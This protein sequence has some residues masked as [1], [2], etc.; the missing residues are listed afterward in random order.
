MGRVSNRMGCHAPTACWEGDCRRKLSGARGWESCAAAVRGGTFSAP[1]RHLV[2]ARPL[3]GPRGRGPLLCGATAVCVPACSKLSL[4]YLPAC[5]QPCA[6]AGG[7]AGWRGRP[8]RGRPGRGWP[9]A[10]AAAGS[11]GGHANACAALGGRWVR[12]PRPGRQGARMHAAAAGAFD[13]RGACS[14]APCDGRCLG[15][16]FNTPTRPYTY[17]GACSACPIRF[18]THCCAWPPAATGAS[19]SLFHCQLK[20]AIT[21]MPA[22]TPGGA[23]SADALPPRRLGGWLAAAV[24]ALPLGVLTPRPAHTPHC[25]CRRCRGRRRHSRRRSRGHRQGGGA[26]AQ[27]GGRGVR[28]HL[29]PLTVGR[30]VLV[31]S[32]AVLRLTAA[33]G[34]GERALVCV[35]ERFAASAACIQSACT[36]RR[37]WVAR[38]GKHMLHT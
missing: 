22:I 33:R 16:Y 20:P 19:T 9:A 4:C 18:T 1:V 30:A 21:A 31:D 38:Q 25:C 34:E 36:P 32:A 10:Q 3:R 6:G 29:L 23:L 5:R 14:C 17:M 12:P 2:H 37:C 27:G 24:C 13:L 35:P 11:Q 8:R 28:R 7:A 26:A 15:T